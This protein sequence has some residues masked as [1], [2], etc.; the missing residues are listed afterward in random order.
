ML[1]KLLSHVENGG[2]DVMF[3]RRGLEIAAMDPSAAIVGKGLFRS[4]DR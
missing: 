3:V 2:S 1:E 4:R